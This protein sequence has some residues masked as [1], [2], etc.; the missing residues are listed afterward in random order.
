MT[1]NPVSLELSGVELSRGE[2]VLLSDLS[3]T[4]KSGQLALVTGPNGSGKTT[5]LRTIAGLAA[6]ARGDIRI[7][8][9]TVMRLEARERGLIAYQ[10]HLEGLKKD[11]TVLENIRF[12]SALRGYSE[13]YSSILAE[14]GLT[15]AADR[16][17]RYLSA[18]Q[19]RRAVLATLRI[20]GARLWL[21]DEPLTNLDPAGRA[22]VVRWVD[23][24]LAAGGLAVV[25]THLADT[26]KRPGTLLV[27]L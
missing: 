8:G 21:L 27:E 15:P 11:L 12:I 23:A 5:L 14:L 24:H 3:F 6:P 7:G 17:V 1:E 4:L 16:K 9:R 18:G 19:K 22:L 25:A 26:L 20:S 10:A 13:E 2:R